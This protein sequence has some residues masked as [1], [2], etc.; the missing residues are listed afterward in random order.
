MKVTERFSD[1]VQDYIKFRPG[2]PKGLIDQLGD[3]LKTHENVNVADVGAGSGI[4]TKL[5][6]SL[7]DQIYAL[8]PNTE[9]REAGADLMKGFPNIHFSHGTG[10]Q[11]GLENKSI[12][13]ITVAQAFHWFDTEKAKEEFRRILTVNGVIALIWNDRSIESDFEIGYEQLLIKYGTDYQEVNHKKYSEKV[14]SA[15]F[16]TSYIGKFTFNNSQGIGP[17][18]PKRKD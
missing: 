4:L 5:L 18:W 8:E 14:L 17:L 6:V 11:T 13:L 10:E 3:L 16:G 9:M 7:S 15:F 12:D 2:Y 1:R